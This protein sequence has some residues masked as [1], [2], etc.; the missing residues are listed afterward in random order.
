MPRS[1]HALAIFDCFK[2]QTT[3][4]V[5][6]LLRENH[7]FVVVPANC[8]DKLQPLDVSMNK[9]FKAKMKTWFQ[10]WYAGEVQE[11]MKES[12]SMKVDVSAAA[13]KLNSAGWIMSS[14]KAIQDCPEL[15]INGFRKTGILDAIRSVLT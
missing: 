6:A 14:R 8:T 15:A 1:Q 11:L 10:V 12:K 2:G 7:D 9:P 3:P 4:Q 5:K 13:I